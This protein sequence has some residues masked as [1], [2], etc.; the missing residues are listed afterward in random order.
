[1]EEGVRLGAGYV[2]KTN[3][4][5]ELLTAVDMVCQGRQFLSSGVAG[6]VLTEVGLRRHMTT[7]P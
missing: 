7:Q 1:M 6:F 2:A 3:A 5:S 4:G